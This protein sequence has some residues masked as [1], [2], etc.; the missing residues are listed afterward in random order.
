MPGVLI[1]D[2]AQVPLAADQHPVGDLGPDRPDPALGMGV[3]P[4]LTG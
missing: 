4:R 3:R 2:H 1:Q